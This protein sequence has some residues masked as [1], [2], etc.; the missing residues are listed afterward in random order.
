MVLITVAYAFT[1]FFNLGSTNA[2]QNPWDF[3]DEKTATF[4]FSEEYLVSKLWY[5]CGLGTG[6]Y[7]VEISSDGVNWLSLWQRKDNA[8]D[9]DE[10]TGYYWADGTGY[11][12]DGTVWGG[13]LLV[14]DLRGFERAGASAPVRMPGGDAAVREPWR[15]ACSWL[16]QALGEEPPALP[17]VE[18]DRWHQVAELARTGVSAPVTTSAGRW[19]VAA[20][21]CRTAA[22]K[23]EVPRKP[24]VKRPRGARGGSAWPPCADRAGCDRGSG[25]RRGG[26]SRAG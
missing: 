20:R 4:A 18:A 24:V 25:P 2:P 6:K 5:F 17:G 13:E 12:T 7:Q 14:G 9:P 19:S 8:D 16:A 21:R 10:V 11:G 1:A 22:A 3:G 23:A 15:M 26:P